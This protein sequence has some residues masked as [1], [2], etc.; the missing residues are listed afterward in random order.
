MTE[1]HKVLNMPEYTW[2]I[3]EDLWLFLNMF[4]YAWIYL[5]VPEW[6]LLY[7]FLVY[8]NVWLLISAFTRNSDEHEGN[9]SNYQILSL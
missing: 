3:S 1:L 6:F 5:N 9:Y 7:L 2:I 8:L 4:E